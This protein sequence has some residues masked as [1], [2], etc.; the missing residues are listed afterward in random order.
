MMPWVE[1][2]C[3]FTIISMQTLFYYNCVLLIL[4]IHSKIG[5]VKMHLKY[6]KMKREYVSDVT[7]GKHNSVRAT[8]S[9]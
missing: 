3:V 2:K 7:D 1:F 4:F 9:R 5:L 8:D 6:I